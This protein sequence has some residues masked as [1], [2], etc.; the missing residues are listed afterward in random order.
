VFDLKKFYFNFDP[1]HV[2]RK[3]GTLENKGVELS[4]SGNVTDRLNIVAG[5]VLSEP[6]VGGEA[7]RLGITGDQPVG[8]TPRKFIFA[9]NWRP[10]GMNGIS[11]DLGLNHFSSVPA[12]L[13]DVAV[14][15]AYSTMD[16]DARY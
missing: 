15:P 4:L 11:F 2:Y 12:T 13:D 14:I 8:V 16:W 10:S 9:V 6:T 5:A 3:L 7:L 1:T